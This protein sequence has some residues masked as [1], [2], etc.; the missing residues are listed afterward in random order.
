MSGAGVSA[1]GLRELLIAAAFG[2]GCSAVVALIAAGCSYY[3]GGRLASAAR[4][5]EEKRDS[6]K[7]VEHFCDML[8]QEAVEYWSHPVDRDNCGKMQAQAAKMSAIL[9]GLA[10]FVHDHFPA[11][12]K[13]FAAVQGAWTGV[14]GGNFA[15]ANR[16]ADLDKVHQ[17]TVALIKLRFVLCEAEAGKD[18]RRKRWFSFRRKPRE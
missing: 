13:I 8:L 3:F 6:L 17:S 7:T 1:V 12:T 18:A 14:T 9:S 10:R 5:W 2:A 15:V 16:R 11:N 4:K